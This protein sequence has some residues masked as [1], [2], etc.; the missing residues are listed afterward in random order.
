MEQNF[1]NRHD[2]TATGLEPVAKIN[3]TLK[4]KCLLLLLTAL[5]A[6]FQ[7]RA[8]GTYSN[9][10]FIENKG[11]WNPAVKYKAALPSGAFFLHSDGFTVLLHNPQEL[12]R[13]RARQMAFHKAVPGGIPTA[14]QA[15]A[16]KLPAPDSGVVHSHAY[17]VHFLGSSNQSEITADKP[18]PTYNNY[19]IGKD[20]ARWASNCR[21]FQ[22][23]TYK[24]IYPHIDIRYF[25]ENGTLKY[26]LIVHPGGD[27][28]N[29]EMEY[30]GADKLTAKNG[31][32]QIKTSVGLVRENVPES[33]QLSQ[34]ARTPVVCNYYQSAA[35][36]IKFAISNYAPDATLV[37]DPALIFF[38]YSGSTSDNWGYTATYDNQGNLY[39]GG[40]VLTDLT[41]NDQGDGFPAS[42]GAYKTTFQGG[43]F[44]IGI[45]KLSPTG[46]QRVYATYIGGSGEEQP[47][48]L[49]VNSKGN[50]IIS[51]RTTSADYPG[52]SMHNGPA[53]GDWDIV[54]T[55]LNGNGSAL[56]G[57]LRLGGSGD[58]GVNIQNKEASSGAIETRRHYGDDARSEVIVDASD[59]IYLASCTQSKDFPTIQ[60]F[61]AVNGG[62]TYS[63]DGVLIK[64]SPD[65]SSLQFCS[66]LGGNGDDAAF[67]LALSP[68]D[69]NIYVAGGTA[70]NNLPNAQNS[71]NG[72]PCDGFVTIVSNS[73][74]PR[75]ISSRY[76]GTSSAD[77]IYGI[78]FNKTGNPFIMGHTEGNIPPFNS[79]FNQ[80][81]QA[82]GNQFI[83]KLSPDLT[84]VVYSANFGTGGG[85]NISPVAFL[86]DKCENV[87]VSGW[88][89]G[90]DSWQY[91]AYI[92]QGA[93]NLG[94]AY[95]DMGTTG[96]SVTPNAIQSST[97]GNDF[98]FFV[99]Q[100][101]AQSQ[102]YGSFFGQ[103]GGFPDHVDGG[104]SR[105][106]KAGIIYQAMCAN[107]D[108]GASFPGVPAS[109]WGPNNASLIFQG[110]Q[111]GCNL[112]GVKIAFNFAGVTAGLKSLINGVYD[113][114]GCVP[115][116]VTFEDT[117][118]NARS[119][120]WNF[121]D[122]S[123]DTSTTSLQVLH[124]FNAVGG[125]LVRLIA[126]D[127]TTCN[128]RDTTYIHINARND[129][130]IDAFTALKLP[131]CQSLA[132]QFNNLS[133]PPAGKP[134]GNSS[135]LWDFGDGSTQ[136]AGTAP[137]N[138]AYGAS[139][140]YKVKLLL[141][142]T[143]YCNF[144][145]SSVQT[146][147]IA[148]LVQAHFLTPATGCAP[149]TAVFNNTSIAGQQFLWNFG[150][151][152]TSTDPSPS[153]LYANTGSYLVQLKVTDSNTCNITDSVSTTLTVHVKPQ[154]AFTTSPIPPQINTPTTF[155][156]GSTGGI[157]YKWLFGDGDTA[158]RNTM[159]TVMHQYNKSTTYQ[160]CLVT[161]NQFGCSD[162]ACNPVQAI[163]Q[164]LMDVPNAF[165]P[166]RFGENG[167][168]K[169]RG[170]GITRLVFRVYN[171]WGQKVF[172]SNDVNLGWDG[173]LNGKPQP[174]D[175]YAYTV[176]AQFFDGTSA[177]KKGDITL[178]R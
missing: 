141:V 12:S 13:A 119:Y 48:S 70:S 27:P 146:I 46:Q 158:F 91:E 8:Q 165:T 54:L 26:N 161:F 73:A 145:D 66:Y 15:G 107:C 4:R 163:I 132:Y 171:R 9:L 93:P 5:S 139:G 7:L 130:A 133:V 123:P 114:S 22:G 131:P 112:A 77:L 124:T 32:L 31:Q 87:Y 82:N 24:D 120:I 156:N 11:Q 49:V 67:V 169:V 164:P 178:I 96:L 25:T 53:N 80:T 38:S 104:T 72:G 125:Y 162:T 37:I 110:G 30:E 175:V 92:Q 159:D 170:Y 100:K 74:I 160:A 10:E 109:V 99:L 35:H 3:D 140:T 95:P 42:P 16:P 155:Y 148:Q 126:I 60:P 115:L 151:G 41:Q 90:G 50:L 65:L 76:F 86:V 118:K 18:L 44:D 36:R 94:P 149:Y 173:T 143:N 64:A 55:E 121:G 157:S 17:R 111:G 134:F 177:T 127:S 167:T 144:P 14:K 105:F 137:V 56:V 20:P 174:M 129:K 63:Q 153:H 166:G 23:V 19:F 128:I 68:A 152:T 45:I 88:G 21:I 85:V 59:N 39:M 101:F 57:S 116:T 172:E 81:Q 52:I 61:A 29:I 106:D 51:G 135:F 117:A 75:V 1:L 138:H 84:S 98:Y 97:D 103:R 33:Y 168:V 2:L 58:D 142:D 147:H 83:T 154:A 102:L 69:N 78:Q 79:P 28:S 34:T 40:I 47:H 62:G 176:V 6:A 122:G 89:G 71:F 150:D 43:S 108:G 136:A 113:S